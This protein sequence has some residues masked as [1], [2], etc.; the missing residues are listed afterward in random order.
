MPLNLNEND[1]N[2]IIGEVGRDLDSIV[3]NAQRRLSK[4]DDDKSSPPEKSPEASAS[5]ESS[6]GDSGGGEGGPPSEGSGDA[7]GPPPDASASASPDAGAGGPP[8]DASASAGGDP[9]MAGQGEDLETKLQALPDDQLRH[10]YMAVK[11]ALFAR[12]SAADPQASASAPG[13]PPPAAPA[14]AASASPSPAAP[15]PAPPPAAAASPSASPAGGPPMPPPGMG[16]GEMKASPANGGGKTSAIKVGKSEP[17]QGAPLAKS[18]PVLP[19]EVQ[20]KLDEQGKMIEGL[21][22][23]VNILGS[24]LRKAV[25]HISQVQHKPGSE[26]AQKPAPTNL[27]KA[28][29]TEKLKSL[30]LKKTT[31]KDRDAVNGFYCGRYGVEKIAHLLG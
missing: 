11:Q 7:G 28:E 14:P 12:M 8:P 27:S 23:A 30:D 21:V 5:S 10:L 16:K 9:A 18:E 20:A 26:P 17:A 31:P 2:E 6:G 1:L 13:A 25:T 15:P 4:A 19:P 3:E 24:P 22:K 29:I